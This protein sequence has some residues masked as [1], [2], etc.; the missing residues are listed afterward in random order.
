MAGDIQ[1]RRKRLGP[2]LTSIG[3]ALL[4]AG[5][6]FLKERGIIQDIVVIGGA[7]LLFTGIFM[8]IRSRKATNNSP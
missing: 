8:T 2:T 3:S 5:V 1:E 4:I 6:F 7:I